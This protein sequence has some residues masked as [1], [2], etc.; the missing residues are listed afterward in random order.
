M[1]TDLKTSL[2]VKKQ[3]P[4]FVQEEYPKFIS[5]LEAYYEFLDIT[6]LSKGKELRDLK[7]IDESLDDFEKEFFNSFLPL[8]KVDSQLSKETL[9]KNILPVYSSKG[10]EKSFK[11]LFRMLFDQELSIEYPRDQIIR[12]SGGR[13][14]KE[15]I[16]R[17]ETTIF[18]EYTSDGIKTV[19][20]LPYELEREQITVYMNDTLITTGF[21]Y[22]KEYKKIIFDVAPPLNTNI[23][24]F[25]NEID[26]DIFA[27]RKVT[28]LASGAYAIVERVGKRTIG[29]LN[30]YQFF[31][32]EK[33]LFGQYRIGELI[34][35]DIKIDDEHIPF[36]LR[37]Y[38][39]VNSITITNPGARYNV[40]DPLIFR[41]DAATPAIAIVNDINTGFIEEIVVL[42]GG[43]GYK[44][45]NE[46]LADNFANTFFRAEVLTVDDSGANTLN[47]I[48]FNTDVISNLASIQ[49]NAANYGFPKAGNENINNTIIS[50]LT[51]QTISNL[52]PITSVNVT[53]SQLSTALSPNFITYSTIAV[54]NIRIGDLGII[55]EIVIDN[56]GQNYQVGNR[57]IFT[58][59]PQE[60]SGQGANATVSAVNGI[61]SI[62]S[63]SLESGG[64]AYN[65]AALPTVTVNTSTGS[66]AS[67]RVGRLV[68]SGESYTFI[69]DEGEVGQIKSIRIISG[70]SGYVEV[71]G[72]D[73]SRSGDGNATATAS[74]TSSFVERPGKWKTSE[75][76]LSND[77][78]RLQGRDY[79]IDFSYVL[80]SQVE[81]QKYKNLLKQLLHPAGLALY[82][83]YT[84]QEDVEP[85]LDLV[86]PTTTTSYTRNVLVV[87]SGTANINS[88]N[89]VTGN[90][91]KFAQ[92]VTRSIIT[93]NVTQ[94]GIAGQVRTVSQVLS[95]T[96]IRV[97]SP[98]T[99]NSNNQ[100]ITI[101][102]Y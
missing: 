75:S 45:G 64:L 77:Q 36:T 74:L 21:Q 5:F 70:G 12:A 16:L 54:G 31:I 69:I 55:G 35:V 65:I 57:L 100:F 23:K 86:I 62:T 41:G 2:L 66:G 34:S 20:L 28:G 95:N 81:F 59:T 6:L 56:G 85:M 13:W 91:T 79:Y 84:I 47:T 29:D 99:I 51:F 78:S 73:L 67:L 7:N 93:P 24:I 11:L 61:G 40:G 94:I 89:I 15:S 14:E 39:D 82:S 32:N 3:L 53:T 52:G 44:V 88:S 38:S 19:Y 97:T 43:I 96:T 60:F 58:N 22:R 68:G 8:L 37:N 10:S 30:F 71:P 63:I 76:L 46:I 72:I 50:V 102:S 83:K 17:I 27:N 42:E 33:T 1:T 90:N 92:F 98:F 87:P 4:T 18:S 80:Y 101:I 9:F 25:Y 49:I 26:G 48:A